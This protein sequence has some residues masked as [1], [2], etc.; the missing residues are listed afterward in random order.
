M[1]LSRL[2]DAP[3]LIVWV[4][5]PDM[6]E[7][8]PEWAGRIGS[9]GVLELGPLSAAASAMLLEAI[10]GGHLE[11]AERRRITDAAGG[12]PLFLEQLVAHVGE[13]L[14]SSDSLPPALHLLLAA[15]LDRLATSERSALALGAVAGDAFEV[16]AVHAL[17]GGMTRAEIEGACDRLVSRDLL[18][19][20]ESAGGGGSYRFRHS[21]VREAAYASLAKS[22]RARLHQRQA[23]WL[24]GLGSDLPDADARIAFHLEAA[25]RYE[26]EIGGSAPDEL[27]SHAG[28]RLAAA[29]WIAR[30]RGDLLGEI[31]FLDRAIALLGSDEEQGAALLPPLVSALFEAGSSDRA[32]L[33]AERAVS[34]SASLGL[35]RIAAWSAIE[36]ERIRLYRHPIGFDVGTAVAVVEQASE[37][38]R[39]LGDDLALGRA[40]YLMADL[41]WLTGDPVASFAHA[42]RML[43]HARRAGSAF[44]A[45]TALTFMGWSLVEG[46]CPT[47]EAIARCDALL[48]EAAGQRAAELTLRGC[49]AA[50][51]TFACGD[52]DARSEMADARAGLA[53]LHLGEIAAYLALLDAVAATVT[54]DLDSAERAVR[55][56]DALVAESGNHW[57]HALIHVDLAHVLIAQERW[58]EAARAVAQVEL[59]A[60]PCDVEWV[61]KRHTARALA[62]AQAGDHERGLEDAHAGV[63]VAEESGLIVC[64]A[65]AYRTLAE[66]LWAT[67]STQ[68]AA[69]A[70]GRA[71]A[72]DEAKVNVVAAEATRQRFSALL[73]TADSGH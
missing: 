16:P 2:R 8:Y 29:A 50:L 21:L 12:N 15:R 11:P 25:C 57:Y 19:R 10:T 1:S 64:R 13:Q 9:E 48:G 43:G 17:A 63:A 26:R 4:A 58:Q 33:L 55:D 22:A 18:V 30:G 42:E 52:G 14:P 66:L 73:A 67:G 34:T 47:D 61:I 32:E 39:G 40:G 3:V 45:A 49:R 54:G 60:A 70:A 5:R 37:T 46:P 28:R 71:L 51:V 62:A 24:D 35:P 68:A 31:G 53:E 36:R 59:L 38:L 23:A 44:D 56:A 6:L 7:R 27:T 65:N 69:E 72:L 20:S 41:A